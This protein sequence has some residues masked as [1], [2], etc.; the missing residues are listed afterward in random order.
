MS[1]I[2]AKRMCGRAALMNFAAVRETSGFSPIILKKDPQQRSI[3][4][5]GT[6]MMIF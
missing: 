1:N 6:K 2:C 5:M 4:A 3:I